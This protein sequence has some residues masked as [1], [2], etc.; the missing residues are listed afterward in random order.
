MAS[1]RDWNVKLLMSHLVQEHG[2]T[3]NFGASSMPLFLFKI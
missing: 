3:L 1:A 2:A